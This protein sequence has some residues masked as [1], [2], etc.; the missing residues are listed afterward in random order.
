[1]AGTVL[2]PGMIMIQRIVSFWI[3][4][5]KMNTTWF[6]LCTLYLTCFTVLFI[7]LWSVLFCLLD[8]KL[9]V[10]FVVKCVFEKISS[11]ILGNWFLMFWRNIVPLWRFCV[12]LKFWELIIRWCSPCLRGM[13]SSTT[14]PWKIKIRVVFVNFLVAG[15]MFEW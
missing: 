12:T 10:T 6:L 4:A 15:L 13:E 1:M 5:R 2:L 9:D 7:R 3:L 8:K 11:D 14:L